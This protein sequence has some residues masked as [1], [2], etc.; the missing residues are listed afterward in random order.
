M[1]N[2][3]LLIGIIAA[4]VVAAVVL[5]IVLTNQQSSVFTAE[6]RADGSIAVNAQNAGKDASVTGEITIG[7]DQKLEIRSALNDK[8]R[9][10]V[11]VIAPGT[12]ENVVDVLLASVDMGRF[13]LAPGTY[14]V[15]ITV[16]ETATGSV[17]IQA[18]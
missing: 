3:K 2:K 5:I 8:G 4:V 1:K 18:V 11:E 10:R 15:R 14:T 13:E 9:V 7:E 12:T 6:T 16:Q 17:D